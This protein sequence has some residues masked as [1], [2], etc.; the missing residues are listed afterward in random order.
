MTARA[1]ARFKWLA[2]AA[3]FWGTAAGTVSAQSQQAGSH[4]SGEYLYRVF[5]ASCHGLSGTGDGPVAPILRQPPSDLTAIA[6]GAGGVF[7]RDQV[8]TKIDGRTFVRAHGTRDMPVW[9][10]RLK[11]TVGPDEPVIRQRIDAI[12]RHLESMQVKK[13]R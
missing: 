1:C 10:D 5:C 6:S 2:F 7:P 9:G 8:I 13:P 4:D 12:A 3:V 11:I